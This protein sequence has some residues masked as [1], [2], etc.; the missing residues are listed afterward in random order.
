MRTPFDQL[1]KKV[2]QFVFE[3]VGSTYAQEE[4]ASEVQ[5]I[6]MWFEPQP[7]PDMEALA[8]LGLFGRIGVE[9]CV[10]EFFHQAPSM[11]QVQDCITKQHQHARARARKAANDKR[12]RPPLPR[13]WIFSAGRPNTVI[14]RYK[15]Q[16]MADWPTGFYTDN[17]GHAM[18]LL[19]V[20]ELPI[21]RDTLILRLLGA[22]TTLM[23]AT[24]ELVALP[25]GS[26][27]KRH[28]MP[29]LLAF[30]IDPNSDLSSDEI[31][32]D[33]EFMAYVHE[34]QAIYAD[35]EAKT[36]AKG[37]QD[38]VREGRQDGLKEGRTEGQRGILLKLLAL[39]FGDVPDAE[40]ER[41][42]AGSDEDIERWAERV[43]TTS[44]LEAV[45]AES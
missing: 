12:P 34:L 25:D 22:G 8:K 28:M 35:W 4:V 44:T 11:H 13:L 21:R 6:D 45:F 36:L 32:N 31:V 38:G 9:A 27:E 3:P 16:P 39:K 14:E 33:E 5:Y 23:D 19:V 17:D 41:V 18:S 42:R 15:L 29:L 26:W 7:Q 10:F 40:V 2:A 1:A 20:R 37:R 30:R 24:R 43:L